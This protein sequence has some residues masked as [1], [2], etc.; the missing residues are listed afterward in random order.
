MWEETFALGLQSWPVWRK[1]RKKVVMEAGAGGGGVSTFCLAGT[2]DADG[3][4]QAWG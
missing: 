1:A 2:S 3:T 4:L